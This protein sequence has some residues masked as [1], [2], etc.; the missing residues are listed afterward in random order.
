M[1]G[2]QRPVFAP[3]TIAIFP[4][5]SASKALI[6]R[7]PRNLASEK[8][9]VTITVYIAEH[10]KSTNCFSS[11]RV[12]ILQ[13]LSRLVIANHGTARP[14]SLPLRSKFSGP[15]IKE[16]THRNKMRAFRSTVLGLNQLSS[17]QTRA[18]S[19]LTPEQHPWLAKVKAP[20]SFKANERVLTFLAGKFCDVFWLA[21]NIDLFDRSAE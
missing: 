4:L 5:N 19:S 3:V 20:A 21:S 7:K 8:N 1:D 6:F 2:N 11:M 10:P 12:C 14:I 9:G 18:F 17:V 13:R 16:A 15:E